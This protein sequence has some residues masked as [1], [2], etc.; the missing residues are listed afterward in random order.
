[1]SIS[2]WGVFFGFLTVEAFDG[3]RCGRV[4]YRVCTPEEMGW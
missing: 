2:H 3:G 4:V 1:M